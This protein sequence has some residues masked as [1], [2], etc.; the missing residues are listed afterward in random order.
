M[1]RP[2][3][4]RKDFHTF[5]WTKKISSRKGHG[6][7]GW[8]EFLFYLMFSLEKE[9]N[10]CVRGEL[11]VMCEKKLFIEANVCNKKTWKEIVCN[12]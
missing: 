1:M 2:L 11:T 9:E 12:K 8:E 4:G 5:H 7:L 3:I 6:K 10:E